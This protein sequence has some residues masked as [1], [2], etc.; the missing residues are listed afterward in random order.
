MFQTWQTVEYQPEEHDGPRE[1]VVI[2]EK[3]SFGKY[4]VRY[5]GS[6]DVFV[7]DV[8]RLRALSKLREE[9]I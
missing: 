8:S 9:S 6:D 5:E 7:T 4:A 1:R 3:L 2:D